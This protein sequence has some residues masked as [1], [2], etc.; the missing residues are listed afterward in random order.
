MLV[1][2]DRGEACRLWGLVELVVSS[3]AVLTPDEL[4]LRQQSGRTTVLSMPA[5]LTPSQ[6]E[7]A[8]M[9]IQGQAASGV[10][11]PE[12]VSMRAKLEAAA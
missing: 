6:V 7:L 9:L 10:V 12:D 8:L 11:T 3:G 4:A 2:L 5:S 1:D